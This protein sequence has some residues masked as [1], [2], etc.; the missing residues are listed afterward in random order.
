[1]ALILP[2][3]IL[4]IIFVIMIV[5]TVRLRSHKP[6]RRLGLTT[7]IL[8][9]LCLALAV[10]DP[11]ISDKSADGIEYAMDA[12]IGIYG[13]VATLVPVWWFAVGR[14]DFRESLDS[15]P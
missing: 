13:C 15:N 14:R 2:G 11:H 9:A 4:P 3:T 1:M 10:L 12:F 8:A 6:L 7:L 5:L